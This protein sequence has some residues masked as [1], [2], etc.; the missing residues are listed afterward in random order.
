M[1][2]ALHSF[3]LIG[4]EISSDLVIAFVEVDETDLVNP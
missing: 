4:D 2:F 3:K 1:N